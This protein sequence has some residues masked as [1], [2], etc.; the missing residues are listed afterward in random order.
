MNFIDTNIFVYTID[1]TDLKKTKIARKLLIEL[2]SAK[3]ACISTQVIHEFCN[4]V[5]KKSKTPLKP[6]D[7]R[8]IIRELLSPLLMHFPDAAFYMRTLEI[9][10]KYSISFYDA[11]I[12]QAATDLNCPILYSED[13]QNDAKY[14][15]VKVVNPF[16]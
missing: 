3:K 4:V 1:E 15:K 11:A 2:V 14:G 10:E 16:V 5:L 12:V 9:F 7:A 8:K 6:A 13:L